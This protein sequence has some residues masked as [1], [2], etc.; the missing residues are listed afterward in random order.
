MATV[1]SPTTPAEQRVVLYNVAW[2]TYERLLAD[3]LDSSVPR[4]TY[5]R[6]VLE[7][8]SPSSEHEETNWTLATLVDVVAEE[9]DIN[10]RNVGSMTF[11]RQDIKR[12]FEPDSSFFI[13]R[14]AEVRGRREID[15]EVDPPPDLL[16]E[17]DVTNQSIDKFP[18]YAQMGV[19]EIW[20]YQRGRVSIHSLDA[21][22]YHET[23]GSI[24]LPPITGAVLTRF[25]EASTRLDR[26][27][28]LRSLREWVRTQRTGNQETT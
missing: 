1:I 15:A 22:T 26:L 14:F 11:R 21:D 23:D 12:G 5:D 25:V 17:I 4:F 19:P 18:I 8:V 3:H 24:V 28:W 13:Q 16:I 7:I 9:L 2:E 20:R 27:H 10:V 6:G